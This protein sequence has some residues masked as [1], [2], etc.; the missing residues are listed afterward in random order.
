MGEDFSTP[1]FAF[2]KPLCNCL[3]HFSQRL[4]EIEL[5]VTEEQKKKNGLLFHHVRSTFGVGALISKTITWKNWQMNH[6][7]VSM[8]VCK[9]LSSLFHCNLV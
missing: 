5:L 1:V 3:R 7:N 8:L 4:S 6:M 9:V 2:P